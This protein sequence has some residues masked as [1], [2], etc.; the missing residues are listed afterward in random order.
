MTSKLKLDGYKGFSKNRQNGNMGG[1]AVLVKEED[2]D[3]VIKAAEG[4]DDNEYIVTRH[5]QFAVP[6]NTRPRGLRGRP[7]N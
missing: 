6:I 5:S 1:V 7:M 3:N 2:N 4:S